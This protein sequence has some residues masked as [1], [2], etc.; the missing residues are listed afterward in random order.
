MDRL[1]SADQIEV[2]PALPALLK[3]YTKEVIRFN[4]SDIPAFSRDYFTALTKGEIEQF[5]E[6]QARKKR[7]AVG[8]GSGS[9]SSTGR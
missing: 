1:Y 5:L 7:E 9:A 4:P 3:A 8:S 6:E 2:P